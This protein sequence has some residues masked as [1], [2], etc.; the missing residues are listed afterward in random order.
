M[1]YAESGQSVALEVTVSSEFPIRIEWDFDDDGILDASTGI[2]PCEGRCSHARSFT[3]HDRGIHHAR[4]R[5]RDVGTK[6]CEFTVPVCVLGEPEGEGLIVCTYVHA[7][8]EGY[9]IVTLDPDSPAGAQTMLTDNFELNRAPTWSPDGTRVAFVENGR[10]RSMTRLGDDLQ[11]IAS[12]GATATLRDLCWSPDGE[13][14]VFWHVGTGIR[15]VTVATGVVTDLTSDG[16]DRHPCWSPSG[17]Q[18]VFVRNGELYTM[19]PDGTIL[20]QLTN[21]PL[22]EELNPDWGP[23]GI[24]YSSPQDDEFG[25]SR[26]WRMD[27]DGMNPT[28]LTSGNY[29]P[30][31]EPTWSPDGM[32]IAFTRVPEGAAESNEKIFV[33]NADGSTPTEIPGQFD[34]HIEPDWR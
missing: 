4:I 25:F 27:A 19:M 22:T 6:F 3:Y 31:D 24:L 32:R 26:I 13:D 14:I 15:R 18:I 16:L 20:L 23:N 11:T 2:V 17:M 9:D 12:L 5:V 29:G 34:V 28:R 7:D 10:I 21:T 30:D 1:K 33:M 8:G